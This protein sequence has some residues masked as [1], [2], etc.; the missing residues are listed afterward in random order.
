MRTH[1]L[2][3]LAFA[4]SVFVFVRAVS[5][6]EL[7]IG[8]GV[9]ETPDSPR[10]SYAWLVEYRQNFSDHLAWSALW[11]NEGHITGHHRDGVGAQLWARKEFGERWS[12]SAGV[13]AYHFFDTQPQFDGDSMIGRGWSPIASLSATYRLSPVWFTRLSYNAITPRH[14]FTSHTVLLSIG[15]YLDRTAKASSADAFVR[16][17]SRNELSVM[18][19]RTIV[20]ASRGDAATA[21][22]IEYRRRLNSHYAWTLSWLDEGDAGEGATHREGPTSQ[23]W[24]VSSFLAEQL[25]IGL[26]AGVYYCVDRNGGRDGAAPSREQEFLAMVS[27]TMAFRFSER[28]LARVVWHRV[29]SNYHRDSDVFL[30]GIGRR[31]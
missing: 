31:W 13:G 6:Q 4:G 25:V 29:I 3:V 5:G 10:S 14:D 30:G 17:D 21:Y 9:M 18:A 11:L 1:V 22:A 19:G 23:L 7:S 2:R 12:L 8:A 28:W 24:L 15:Y 20:N 27:P 16:R 26:G